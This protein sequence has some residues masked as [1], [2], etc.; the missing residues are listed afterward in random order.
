MSIRADE[1]YNGVVAAGSCLYETFSGTVGYQV[2]LECEEGRASYIIW[3]TPKNRERAQKCF[4][5]LGISEEQLK[6]PSFFENELAQT[7]EGKEVSFGTAEE[8]WKGKRSVKVSWIGKASTTIGQKVPSVA[9]QF[10]G[11]ERPVEIT[12]DDIPF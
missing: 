5:L 6:K 1:K 4:E 8:E 9:A 10:F 12:D 3:L 11:G 7:I 2:M